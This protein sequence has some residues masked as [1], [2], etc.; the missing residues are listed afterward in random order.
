MLYTERMARHRIILIPLLVWALAII[1][2][3]LGVWCGPRVLRLL[4]QQ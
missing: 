4:R 3:G 2:P 1:V